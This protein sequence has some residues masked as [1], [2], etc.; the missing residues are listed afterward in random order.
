MNTKNSPT[1]SLDSREVM[2]ET[3]NMAFQFALDVMDESNGRAPSRLTP[4]Q[5]GEMGYRLA[6]YW[7]MKVDEAKVATALAMTAQSDARMNIYTSAERAELENEAR[8][9]VTNG[10]IT[11]L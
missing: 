9:T 7:N 3:L 4:K 1:P 8:A 10:A 5:A 11:T 6:E 2:L